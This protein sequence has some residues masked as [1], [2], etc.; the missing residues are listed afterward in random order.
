M[1]RPRASEVQGE[2]IA[3]TTTCILCFEILL[4]EKNK[5]NYFNLVAGKGETNIEN[6]LQLLS[7]YVVPTSKYICRKCLGLIKR[8][9]G[10]W[11]KLE[12]IDH[13]IGQ[14]YHKGS[15]KNI[16]DFN[17][18]PAKRALFN[19]AL[20]E[21]VSSKKPFPSHHEES[22][23]PEATTSSIS[24]SEG[25]SQEPRNLASAPVSTK[26]PS[27][28]I[29]EGG[30][31]NSEPEACKENANISTTAF[32][33][34]IWKSQTRERKLPADLL[35]LGTMLCRGTYRQIAAAAWRNDK[36]RGH[37]VENFLKAVDAEC[38]RL[39]SGPRSKKPSD[40]IRGAK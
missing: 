35:S 18:R 10:H 36:L 22:T 21:E 7:V 11:K 19:E 13:E 27:I 32:I 8:R 9:A 3:K 31:K 24:F 23:V 5:G 6:E 14:L 34:V 20:C 30:K 29:V 17:Q 4:R 2:A 12:D 28:V 37:L 33:K 39:C 1:L 16:I 40:S 26:R 25:I 15:T 38:C